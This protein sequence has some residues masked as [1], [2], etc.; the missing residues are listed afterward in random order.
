M[1]TETPEASDPAALARAR[2]VIRMLLCAAAG[3]VLLGVLVM[4]LPALG[5]APLREIMGAVV[6]AGGAFIAVY[7]VFLRRR[8]R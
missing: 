2:P 3:L 5:R 4:F 6:I 8:L 1:N 7:A